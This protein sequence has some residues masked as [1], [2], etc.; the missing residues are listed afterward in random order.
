MTPQQTLRLDIGQSRQ[1][2]KD[3][4]GLGFDFKLFIGKIAI[5]LSPPWTNIIPCITKK[6]CFYRKHY[7]HFNVFFEGN[8]VHYCNCFK[9]G[10]GC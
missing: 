6:D 2:T 1:Y 5:A 7:I 4:N 9:E 10:K 8:K 3:D